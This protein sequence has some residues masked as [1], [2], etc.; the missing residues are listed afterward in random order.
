MSRARIVPI[1][2]PTPLPVGSVNVFLLASDPVTLVDAGLNTGEAFEV[3]KAAFK[4][5]GLALSDLE[6]VLLTHTHIDHVGLLGRLRDY[7]DFTVYAHPWAAHRSLNSEDQHE[8]AR[9]FG[10]QIMR[11]LG[12]PDDV[13]HKA[14]G[15][16]HSFREFATDATV[17]KGLEDGEVIGPHTACH[18]PGHSALD[19]LFVDNAHR[20]AFTG[21]HLLPRITPNP[22]LRRPRAG[23]PR[24]KSL[25]QYR[26]SLRKTHALDLDVCYPGHGEPIRNHR[27]VIES[28]L[29]RQHKRNQRVLEILGGRR[30]S[31]YEVARQLFPRMD[32]KFT[33]LGLSSAAGHLE[34]LE[35]EGRVVSEYEDGILCFRAV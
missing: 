14:A 23:Q 28:L 16:Q 27:A 35:E 11:E 25:V 20:I 19:M 24:V 17:D 15:E 34:I 6:Q 8:K 10:L 13:A 7:A 32:A 12:A 2:I 4:N 31:V 26:E 5:E 9:R 21:D 29:E 3:L 18:V 33:F 22:L 1:S 30:L